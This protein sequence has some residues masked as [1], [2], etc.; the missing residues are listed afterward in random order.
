[1]EFTIPSNTRIG[2][3]SPFIWAGYTIVWQLAILYTHGTADVSLYRSIYF[4]IKPL[5]LAALIS[6]GFFWPR[7][8]VGV[9]GLLEGLACV[10][11][12]LFYIDELAG[13]VMVLGA[14]GYA[15]LSLL[16]LTSKSVGR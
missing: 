15:A 5:I 3:A 12:G 7:V 1:M 8:V 6:N 10:I 13:V 2:Q 14:I 16:V 11:L 4:S 9:L